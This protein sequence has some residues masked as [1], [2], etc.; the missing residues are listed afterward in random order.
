MIFPLILAALVCSYCP[1]V[2]ASEKESGATLDDVSVMKF[3]IED[4]GNPSTIDVKNF[5][6]GK[7]T[8]LPTSAGRKFYVVTLVGQLD[9]LHEKYRFV[10]KE[11]KRFVALY[12]VGKQK[13]YSEG[14]MIMGLFGWQIDGRNWVLAP[15]E[16]RADPGW[17]DK[18]RFTVAFSLPE[19]WKKFEVTVLKNAGA[20]DPV[21]VGEIDTQKIQT[22]L[23]VARIQDGAL[24]GDLAGIQAL[25]DQQPELVASH[26][27]YG[28]TP[29]HFAAIKGQ[30]ELVQ[31]LLAHKADIEAQTS[32]GT[33]ALNLAARNGRK[34]VV[35]LLLANKANIN[36]TDNN[37]WT[38]LHTAAA[39][40]RKEVVEL[41]LMRGAD[42]N[43]KDRSGGTPLRRATAN[44]HPDIAQLIRQHGGHE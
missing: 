23:A 21:R 22:A 14:I 43:A 41:L 24:V 30:E 38:P 11:Q 1:A 42:V 27:M 39:M 33:T 7:S 31:L 4:C 5:F 18:E 25:L 32:S 35:E 40:D 13:E 19:G 8:T 16:D 6:T 37:G 9:G 44:K 36:A 28:F 12:D 17:R 15:K 34:T 29:L 2:N 3:S 20:G 26:D 10:T